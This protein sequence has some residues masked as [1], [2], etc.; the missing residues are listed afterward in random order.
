LSQGQS[1]K[2]KVLKKAEMNLQFEVTYEIFE[3]KFYSRLSI[4]RQFKKLSANTVWTEI[5]S[6]IKGGIRASDAYFG[7]L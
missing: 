6:V 2:Q 1:N 3:K 5:Y 7:Y 4:Q